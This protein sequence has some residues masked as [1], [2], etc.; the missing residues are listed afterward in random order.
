MNPNVNLRSG[1]GTT[2]RNYPV[3]RLP[4][5]L[6]AYAEATN[7]FQAAPT[8]DVYDAVNKIRARVSMPA[9]PITAED[10]TKE[11]MRKRIRNEWRVE[12]AFENHRFWDVRRW[13][14]AKQVDNGPMYGLNAR[15]SQAELQA[16]GLDENSE[17]AGVAVF[18]K[19]TVNQNR[20]FT[21]KHYLFPIPQIEVN[22]N[23]NLVQN[24][25]W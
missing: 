9:L 8:Q 14:I 19:Q 1:N 2:N 10:R 7:E 23:P 17:A 18:Y 12:F 21:D 4:E 13:L 20:V 5:M 24:Y 11:G 15:P 25:G 22:K 16:T 3:I 6:L